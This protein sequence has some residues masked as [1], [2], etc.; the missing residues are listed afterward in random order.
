MSAARITILQRSLMIGCGIGVLLLLATFYSVVSAAVDHA[1]VRRAE[2]LSDAPVT[3]ARGS[4]Q[5]RAVI[6]AGAE[7]SAE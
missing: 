2:W 3:T 7:R 5:R 4:A 6:L 1:A